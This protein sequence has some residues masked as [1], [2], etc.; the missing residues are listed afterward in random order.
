MYIPNTDDSHYKTASTVTVTQTKDLVNQM[1][2]VS[3]TGFTPS[4]QLT[5]DNGNTDYPVMLAECAGLNPK[6][7]DDCYDATNG[8]TPASFGKYGCRLAIPPTPNGTEYLSVHLLA[9]ST[10]PTSSCSRPCRTSS[11]T[12][13]RPIPA[14]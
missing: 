9:C 7:P 12:A 6:S 2:E 5:Y 1:V 3:W 11:S 14:R 13:T 8:G 4:S 10:R